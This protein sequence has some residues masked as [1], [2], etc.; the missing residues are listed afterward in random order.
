MDFIPRLS[1]QM[2]KNLPSGL[3]LTL[4]TALLKWYVCSTV[5]VTMLM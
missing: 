4:V 3:N 5:L 1:L 2:A